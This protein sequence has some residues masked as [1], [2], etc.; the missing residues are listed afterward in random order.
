MFGDHYVYTYPAP[1]VNWKMYRA[2]FS[3]LQRARACISPLLMIDI[4]PRFYCLQPLCTRGGGGHLSNNFRDFTA[5]LLA[6]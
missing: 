6:T 2:D 4:L 3:S 1:W 5:R